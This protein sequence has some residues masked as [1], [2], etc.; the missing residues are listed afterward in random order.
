MERPERNGQ[1]LLL[2]ATA[3][4]KLENKDAARADLEAAATSPFRSVAAQAR[5]RLEAL[6]AG[7]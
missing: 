6:S 5:K 3:Y 2:R 7:R 1:T 4:E